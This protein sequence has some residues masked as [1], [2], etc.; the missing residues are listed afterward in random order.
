MSLK[1]ANVGRGTWERRLASGIAFCHLLSSAQRPAEEEPAMQAG[2]PRL[3][4]RE[5]FSE[6]HSG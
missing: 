1:P 4:A 3:E 5:L 6:L 2:P